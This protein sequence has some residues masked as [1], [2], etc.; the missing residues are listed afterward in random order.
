MLLLGAV[1]LAIFCNV[2]RVSALVLLAQKYGA[3]LLDTRLHPASGII[4][5]GVVIAAL[6]AIAGPDAMRSAA[7]TGHR[8]AVS[9]R[10]SLALAVLC[11]LA[12]LPV[13]V[14]ANARLRGDDCANPAAL[15]PSDG[16]ADPE[17]AAFMEQQF[18]AVQ[19]REGVLAPTADSP[20]LRFTVIRSY[21]PRLLYYRGT[22]RLWLEVAPGGDT[23]EWLES[24]DGRLPIV[25]SQ[26][27]GERAELSR[28][29]IA[30]LLVY[31]G[32]PVE[33]GWRA[34]LREAPRQVFT[35]SRPMTMFTVRADVLPG[36][37]EAAERRAR[38]Y[39]LDSWR[40][41]RAV[42]RR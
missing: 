29:V 26:I 8:T 30:S 13:A 6:F 34:Q 19:W 3:E 27:Q 4:L 16:P 9:G 15:V 12:L 21:E 28:T 37:R 22:R 23:I 5:F 31:G 20:E 24:D 7:A 10:F 11:A 1:P 32:E 33:S 14:H 40:T 42:C 17:R 35:G 18:A 39:L 38:E 2:L 36:N 25:R 41:Y